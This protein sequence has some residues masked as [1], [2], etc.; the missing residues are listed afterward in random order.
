M[1]SGSNLQEKYHN[2][3]IDGVSID[4]RKVEKGQLFIPII[5]ENFNGHEFIEQAI[6]KGAVATLWNKD[7]PIP[8]LDFPVIPITLISN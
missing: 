7:E 3:F 8:N 4:T 6:E 5:G 1:V 2:I